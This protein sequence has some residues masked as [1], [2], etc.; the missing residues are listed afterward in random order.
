MCPRG[1]IPLLWVKIDPGTSMV[2]YSPSIR[3]NPWRFPSLPS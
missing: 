1:L 2:R 3:M